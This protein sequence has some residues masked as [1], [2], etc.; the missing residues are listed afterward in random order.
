MQRLRR[1]PLM[2]AMGIVAVLVLTGCGGSW[3]RVQNVGSAPATVVLTYL[4]ED[5]RVVTTDTRVL[6]P[7]AATNFPQRDNQN[8]PDGYEGSAL[9]ESDQPIIALR[10]VDMK[11][12]TADMV[13]GGT[14]SIGSG[15]TSVYL[16]L[17]MNQAGPWQTWNSRF[18]IQNLSDS[19]TACVTITYIGEGS[20]TPVGYDPAAPGEGRTDP[21]CPSGGRPIE[22][23]AT[24]AR[25]PDSFRAPAGFAGAVRIDSVSNARGVPAANISATAET[26][27]DAFNLVTSYRGLNRSEAGSTVLLPLIEREVGPDASFNTF[28]HM[29]AADTARVV[30]VRLHIEGVDGSGAPVVKDSEF[31]FRGARS[32]VQVAPDET[33]CLTPGDALPS[34]FSGWARLEASSAITAVVERGSYFYGYGSYAGTAQSNGGSRIALPAVNRDS[35]LRIMAAGVGTASV[36]A[37]YI[38]EDGSQRT[39]NFSVSGSTT[40][41]VSNHVADGFDGAAFLEADRPIVVVASYGVGGAGPDRGLLYDGVPLP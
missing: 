19:A 26:W 37:R 29:Q 9:I 16:P 41:F 17:V 30:R 38:S 23:R 21:A 40:V 39:A 6:A 33:N 13:D 7:G 14:L 8:L 35:F 34:G 18:S 2:L 15:G 36:T 27:N 11:G 3:I 1:M 25:G 22:P 32:C 5:G 4:D 20:G 24:L 31:S 28:V 10:R 12:L